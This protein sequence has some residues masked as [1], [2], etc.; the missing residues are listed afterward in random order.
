MD[1]PGLYE[2]YEPHEESRPIL[3]SFFCFDQSHDLDSGDH[4]DL[5]NASN[6]WQT[7]NS[8]A[9][10][11]LVFREIPMRT[12]DNEVTFHS[13]QRIHLRLLSPLVHIVLS[14]FEILTIKSLA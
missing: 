5:T 2:P 1:L 14:S 11:T 7:T 4:Q 3:S 12:A 9:G 8:S 13:S 6:T 10:T